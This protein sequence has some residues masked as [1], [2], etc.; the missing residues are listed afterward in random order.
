MVYDNGI[1]VFIDT[2]SD[3]WNMDSVVLEKAFEIYS[4]VKALVVAQLYGTL[5]KIVE[6]KKIA[7]AY[8]LSL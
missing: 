8:G 2:E 5:G 4:D 1:P 3:T 6:I 7:T